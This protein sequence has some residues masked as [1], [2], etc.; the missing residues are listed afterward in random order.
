MT[1]EIKVGGE[2]CGFRVEG[3][4]EIA[5]IEGSAYVMRHVASGARLI[6][7]K[8][9]DNNKS[10]SISFKTP[11]NNNTGV[12]HILEHSVLNGSKKFPV[13]EPFVNLIKNSMQ[14][15]L[16]AMTFAD[17]TMFPVASTNEQDLLNL[18]DVYMDAVLHPAIYEKKHIFEQE[19]WHLE[20]AGAQGAG[21]GEE[22]VAAAGASNAQDAAASDSA[23][24]LT[25]N[26][27]VY[28][29]M[30]GALSDPDSVLFDAVCHQ[31][32]PNTAYGFESGGDPREIPCLTYQD[33]I[34][35][36]ARHYNLSNAYITLY[37]NMN[38]R[39]FLE[40]LDKNYLSVEDA[41]A[42]ARGNA[43]AEAL[44]AESAGA[45]AAANGGAH[46]ATVAAAER[47]P[48]PLALQKPVV[49]LHK[50]VKMRTTKDN[51][52]VAL[53]YVVGD[54][55]DR[56][57]IFATNIL[58]EAL[59][60]CNEAPLKR[61]LLDAKLGRDVMLHVQDG[62]LQPFVF[63]EVQGAGGTGADGASGN[64][65]GTGSSADA[66][67]TTQASTDKPTC[68]T[69]R[70]QQIIEDEVRKL[71]A[72]GIDHELL[73]ATL[74][75]EKFSLREG[76][77]GYADG[78]AHAISCM[79]GW[80]Y[81]D[82]LC[83]AYLRYEDMF[84]EMEK[85]VE[86]NYFEELLS[87][88]FLSNAHMASVELVPQD[89]DVLGEADVRLQKM[90][91]TIS[92]AEIE[93]IKRDTEALRTEQMLDD[94]PQDLAK[95]P[96]L[97]IDEVGPAPD[98]PQYALEKTPY[99]NVL[100]HS[101]K[102]RGIVYVQQ[103]YDLSGF[104]AQDLPYIKLMT[105]ML[106]G[107][108]TECHTAA[109]L[110]PLLR[111]NIGSLEYHLRFYKE[112]RGI[113]D[114]GGAACFGEEED[115]AGAGVAEGSAGAG[116][117]EGSAGAAAGGN[118]DV[119]NPSPAGAVRAQDA[120]ATEAFYP[121]LCVEASALSENAATLA[122]LTNEISLKTKFEDKDKI[123]IMLEQIKLS[124]EQKFCMSGHKAAIKRAAAAQGAAEAA[125]EIAGGVE[126]YLFISD[127][128][129]NFDEKINGMCD[130]FCALTKA[131]FVN[132]GCFTS[133]AGGGFV[134]SDAQGSNAARD[135]YLKTFE[136]SKRECAASLDNITAAPQPGMSVQ[137]YPQK[138]EAFI[139]P[140]D[141][142]FTGIAHNP[143]A[144]GIDAS[145]TSEDKEATAPA[146]GT[147]PATEHAPAPHFSGA[148]LIASRALTYG[149]LWNEV[150]VKGGAYGVAATLPSIGCCR[151]N[152]YRDPNLDETCARFEGGAAWL[153][154][155]APAQDEWVGYVVSSVAGLDA[156]V[157]PRALIKRQISHF[158]SGVSPE[159]RKKTRQEIIDSS[160]SD[161]QATAPIVRR[162]AMSGSRCV[163]GSADII[164]ASKLD[165]EVTELLSRLQKQDDRL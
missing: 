82:E 21:V 133:F 113:C 134:G 163:F 158:V 76:N 156:P 35:T 41:S 106:S 89:T 148:W 104:S 124:L 137:P 52:C 81:D 63:V 9:E 58:I 62:I 31:L 91:E 12:F 119:A 108:D 155:F 116:V 49:N 103:L 28:N 65:E 30:K 160:V 40:F 1:E 157:K 117:A 79:E 131:I 122:R 109:Q 60:G 83:T 146:A 115:A 23:P 69:T 45:S 84:A 120:P 136:E 11:P 135:E 56:L 97:R 130:K 100:C 144:A 32:F 77:F 15:F 150:R 123:K 3:A 87:S 13:K 118:F 46:G 16:N 125:A 29:E 68:S 55:H 54:I 101:V 143:W 96:H 149:Y 71:V 88:L 22:G 66:T 112:A 59:A 75:Y 147:T 128:C 110:V 33:F 10:F 7:L 95:L 152:S 57:R 2:I 90:N 126:Y 47:K 17:K 8:N 43:G 92:A 27:V 161:V 38:V 6:Y 102:T 61:A 72:S 105:S 145:A 85:L 99:G 73:R 94:E 37:G 64:A 18:T 48:N 78:V 86:T 127:L 93:K 154:N 44:G 25:Y 51:A 141:V 111:K 164:R 139:V 80:L 36:H 74:A 153:K 151:F 39:N 26:G 4:Q 98:E 34:D 5:E 70:L 159:F 138:N 121:K 53:G 107:L 129:E 67:A 132:S 162:A 42:V 140:A 19:G 24:T 50:K 114:C 142:T 14:T 165:W 20:V